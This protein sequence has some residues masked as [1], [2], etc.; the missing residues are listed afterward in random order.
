MVITE[1]E[2]R[3]FWQNGRGQIPEFPA[4]TRFT[5]SALD[6]LKAV[7]AAQA[8][9]APP[10]AVPALSTSLPIGTR[11]L[12]APPGQ[13]L[14][15]TSRDLDD[16]LAGNPQTLVLH[17]SVTVTDAAKEMLRGRGVRLV[18]FVEKTVEAGETNEELIQIIKKAVMARMG[19]PVDE[20]L[21]E[22]VV[23]RVVGGMG[24]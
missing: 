4:G 11:E 2:L 3:Q 16:L 10:R 14:I 22:R 13:R 21:V 24:K 5:P 9:D 8:L 15:Y 6:F 1:A 17:P 7:G 19:G 12:K 23:R 18:P 20:A